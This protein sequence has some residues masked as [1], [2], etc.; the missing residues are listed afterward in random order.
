MAGAVQAGGGLSGGSGG[1]VDWGASGPDFVIGYALTL[2]ALM[3]VAAF[4]VRWARG[5]R[6][7]P[8]VSPNALTR[9]E[10]AYLTGGPQRVVETAVVHLHARELVATGPTAGALTLTGLPWL[11]SP[12]E[13]AVRARIGATGTGQPA[14][15]A[16]YLA[17]DP[18]LAALRAHLVR[19]HLSPSPEQVR[20][21]RLAALVFVPLFAVGLRRV[22]SGHA[23]HSSL[24]FLIFE[25]VVTIV[26]ALVVIAVSSPRTPAGDRLVAQLRADR[27]ELRT[28]G[29]PDERALAVAVFGPP[30]LLAAAPDLARRLGFPGPSVRGG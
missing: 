27:A 19:Q 8:T 25:L 5:P 15:L 3:V 2:L 12:A 9:D 30:A 10:V 16:G 20:A 11:L 28:G 14:R 21:V 7:A 1:D 6:E 17:A 23:R 26:A 29:G 22:V 18:A 24:G 4:L 13:S